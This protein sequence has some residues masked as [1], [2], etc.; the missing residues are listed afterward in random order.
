MILVYIGHIHPRFEE[1]SG[2]YLAIAINDIYIFNSRE[3]ANEFIGVH[4]GMTGT[5]MMIPL[6]VVER[7]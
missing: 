3:D 7:K 2:D 4:A 6:I 1:F 5:E